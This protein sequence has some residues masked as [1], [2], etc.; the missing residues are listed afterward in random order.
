MEWTFANSTIDFRLDTRI[1]L[2]AIPDTAFP[3]KKTNKKRGKL[4]HSF[5]ARKIKLCNGTALCYASGR[6][7]VVGCAGRRAIKAAVREVSDFFRSSASDVR[8]SNIVGHSHYGRT[9]RLTDVVDACV[10]VGGEIRMSCSF[11]PEIYPAAILRHEKKTT[12][13]VFASG[14]VIVTGAKKKKHVTKM[15][16]RINHL[17]KHI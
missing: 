15:L 16:S 8:I 4:S 14:K 5:A 6:V 7:V 10:K 2:T 12:A 11:E 13:L 1:D 3:V 9:L 17:L